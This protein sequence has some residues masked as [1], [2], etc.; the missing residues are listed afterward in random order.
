MTQIA[1]SHPD[2]Q[3]SCL[4]F[5]LFEHIKIQNLKNGDSKEQVD[6][7]A[8]STHPKLDVIYSLDD[9]F[10]MTNAELG[11]KVFMFNIDSNAS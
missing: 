6:C 11:E 3:L 10:G 7:N 1:Q 2:S 8:E 5:K 4:E 9:F